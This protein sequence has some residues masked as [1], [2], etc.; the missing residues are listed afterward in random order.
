MV[1]LMLENDCKARVV[2][3]VGFTQNDTVPSLQYHFGH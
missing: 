1:G 2:V 3:E